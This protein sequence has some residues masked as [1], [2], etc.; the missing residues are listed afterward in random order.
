MKICKNRLS[1][2]GCRLP[3]LLHHQGQGNSYSSNGWHFY[4]EG[5][6]FGTEQGVQTRSWSF[7]FPYC[8]KKQAI[9]QNL[10]IFLSFLQYDCPNLAH[11]LHLKVQLKLLLSLFNISN[12][13]IPQK[14]ENRWYYLISFLAIWNSRLCSQEELKERGQIPRKTCKLNRFDSFQSICQLDC[15][16]CF[17][18]SLQFISWQTQNSGPSDKSCHPLPLLLFSKNCW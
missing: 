18:S 3:L 9:G 7:L 4:W 8:L 6:D 1:Q 11:F 10:F 16:I 13:Y 5:W 14:I 15:R 2:W 17:C 12:D